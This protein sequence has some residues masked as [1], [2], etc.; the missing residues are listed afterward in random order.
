MASLTGP[1]NKGNS[2][3]VSTPDMSRD[4]P[5]VDPAMSAKKTAPEARPNTP[6]NKNVIH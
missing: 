1:H 3:Y 4:N 2:G 5:D 6:A